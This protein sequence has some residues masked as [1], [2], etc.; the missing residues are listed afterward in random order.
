M[1]S[2][3][4]ANIA[5]NETASRLESVGIQLRSARE[6]A[7]LSAAQLADSLHMGHE[8]LD[9]LERG[10]RER[11]PEPVFIKAMTRRVAA[12]L[13]LDADP[14]IH[15]LTIALAA[16]QTGQSPQKSAA[17]PSPAVS[18][19]RVSNAQSESTPSATLW[20]SVATIALLG[21]VGV[22]SALVFAKQR[23]VP[24]PAVA[25]NAALPQPAAETAKPATTTE[26]DPSLTPPSAAP[27]V[28]VTSQEPSWLE[29]RNAD[30]ETIYV[31]TLNDETPLAVN[32]GD[33]IYAGR[34]DLVL[35][36]NGN[37]QPQPLGDISDIRWHKITPER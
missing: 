36:S 3:A 17:K 28:T 35:I 5:R 23:P 13:Q 22:G 30:R 1:S 11:L 25:V 20:K 7:G 31:G 32:P 9:A 33:E 37:N 18:N 6:A 19:T 24:T 15:E 27:A 26:A 8:Q 16:E 34:P 29:V 2:D 21:G 14:L 12:R 10:D 4:S